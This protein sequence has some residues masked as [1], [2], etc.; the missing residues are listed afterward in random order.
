MRTTP[1]VVLHV[2]STNVA[3]TVWLMSDV[4]GCFQPL[5]QTIADYHGVSAMLSF[6]AGEEVVVYVVP[7]D[8]SSPES[9]QPIYIRVADS[10][11]EYR[12][13][14]TLF[15]NQGRG[16]IEAC[17]YSGSIDG[18]YFDFPAGGF[19]SVS[20]ESGNLFTISSFRE[21]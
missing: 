14:R 3:D 2:Y 16:R 10:W 6:N 19:F 5:P 15:E 20:D 8:A 21:A 1:Y 9:T 18:F 7:R 12:R 4:I 17:L 13:I 11:R